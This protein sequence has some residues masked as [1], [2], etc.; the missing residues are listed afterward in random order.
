MGITP[1]QLLRTEH[2]ATT[3]MP[4]FREYISQVSDAVPIGTR[5]AYQ[6]YWQRIIDTWGDRRL[7]EPTPLEIKKLS[8]S[9]KACAV[10]RKN[11]RGGRSAAEHLIAAL[12]C[13]YRHAAADGLITDAD[14]PAI[15][16][17][18]PRR[19]P[20]TRRAIPDHRLAEIIKIAATTGND[21]ELDTLLLR[22]HTETACRRGGALQLRPSDLDTEQCLILLHEKGETTRWQPVSPT[23]MHHLMIHSKERGNGSDEQ[24]LC[25]RNRQPITARR[26]DH[27]WSRIGQHLPWVATQQI[28]THWLRHTTLTWVERNFGYAIAR[29]YAGHTGSSDAGSTTTYIRADLH[30]VASALAALTQEPHPLTEHGKSTILHHIV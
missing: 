18:K 10:T 15:R 28:S 22:L 30:E 21:P 17:P 27:L 14:N 2:T 16:V 5:R 3:H 13:L 7:D 1:E 12:R 26:Y 25:Y 9:V 19:L 23:L 24:L 4:T 29:A 6:T 20:S 8:E 11:S